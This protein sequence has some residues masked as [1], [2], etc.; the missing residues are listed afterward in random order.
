MKGQYVFTIFS[1]LAAVS[2]I[3]IIQKHNYSRTDKTSAEARSK[4][5]SLTL[6]RN[7]RGSHLVTVSCSDNIRENCSIGQRGRQNVGVSK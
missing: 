1:S 4:D 2:Y 3:Y 6:Q 7:D 5:L